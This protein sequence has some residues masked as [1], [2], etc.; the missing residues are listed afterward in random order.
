MTDRLLQRL[1]QAPAG[2][3]FEDIFAASASRLQVIVAFLALLELTKISVVKVRQA[4]PDAAIYILPVDL[5]RL[6]EQEGE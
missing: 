5:D 4:T 2:I 6:T 1:R 3:R